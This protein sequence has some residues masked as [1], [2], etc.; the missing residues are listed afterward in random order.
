MPVDPDRINGVDPD[1]LRGNGGDAFKVGFVFQEGAQ[2]NALGYYVVGPDGA[3][4]GVGILFASDEAAAPGDAALTPVLAQGETL[5]LFL[6]ADGAARNPAGALDGAGLAFVDGR[7]APA[8]V[9]DPR[10]RLVFDDGTEVGGR[11]LH[12]VAFGDGEGNPLNPQDGVRALSGLDGEG[13]L[14]VAFEDKAFDPDLDFNDLV[15]RV[16]HEPGEPTLAL[17]GDPF[18]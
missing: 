10:P 3:I 15:I 8:F 6:V 4:G 9:D 14:L 13:G 17:D 2:D 5:G 18:A 16:A 11:V 12:A 7:G 1:L